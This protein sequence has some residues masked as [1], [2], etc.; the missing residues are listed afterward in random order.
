[1]TAIPGDGEPAR[2]GFYPDPSVPGWVRYWNGAHWMPGTSR[3]LDPGEVV[4]DR[5]PAAP[6]PPPT[7]APAPA[8]ALVEET[9]PVFLDDTSLTE[10]PAA[11][12]PHEPEP[13][14]DHVRWQADP[15]QQNGYG[16]PRDHLISWG[17]ADEEPE[18]LTSPRAPAPA[19]AEP[20]ASGISLRR[21]PTPVREPR[22]EPERRLPPREADRFP[23]QSAPSEPRTTAPEDWPLPAPAPTAAPRVRTPPL[24]PSY[25][26]AAPPVR[27][28]VREPRPVPPAPAPAPAA[29][30]PAR[31]L[32]PAPE[33]APSA[34]AVPAASPAA[35]PPVPSAPVPSEESRRAVAEMAARA[36]RPAGL[37]RRLAARLL[38]TLVYAAVAGATA[39]P[40]LP[41]A[42]AH[43][44][45]KVA[46][47]R[48]AGQTVTVWVLDATVLGLLGLVLAAVLVFGLVW[49]VLPTA[50]WGRTPGKRL[51]GVRVLTHPGRE[52]PGLGRALARWFLLVLLGLPGA[53]AA[54]A[55]PAHRRTW[56]DRAAGTRVG[57]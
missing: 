38:D 20:V 32:P 53:L 31:P 36:D 8:P 3:P 46:A 55:D 42:R 44:D 45:A 28:P 27:E 1:M 23:L 40:L 5:N 24:P 9:G 18:P 6:P 11:G 47:S 2:E 7:P 22:P 56:H 48:V 50:R 34:A 4:P 33:P 57:R 19:A 14:R 29:P 39:L 21:A 17:R 13:E 41:Q 12:G 16:G 37:G 35:V 30:A 54:L 43:L 49:E 26:P 52:R 51:C 15:Q 10:F 25:V